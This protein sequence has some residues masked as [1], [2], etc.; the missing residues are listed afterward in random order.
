V[1]VRGLYEC[2]V[3]IADLLSIVLAGVRM[4]GLL[5]VP[6]AYFAEV[7]LGL[8]RNPTHN[9]L[10]DTDHVASEASDSRL[11]WAPYRT[12]PDKNLGLGP[13]FACFA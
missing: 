7:P 13:D 12:N 5:R 6:G 2:S 8:V 4:R 1:W 10:R 9:C 3:Q 11:L